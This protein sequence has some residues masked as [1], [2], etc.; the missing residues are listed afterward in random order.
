MAVEGVH[1]PGGDR[2]TGNCEPGPRRQALGAHLGV[3]DGDQRVDRGA[4]GMGCE[5]IETE[6]AGEVGDD[7]ARD[8]IDAGGHARDLG[9][10][11]RHDHQLHPDRGVTGV[12][13]PAAGRVRGPAGG[14]QGQRQ[15]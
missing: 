6:R 9:V 7:R 12:I 4:P 5:C 10:R 2:V 13:A 3:G 1:E 14:L 11:R 15:C 8:R